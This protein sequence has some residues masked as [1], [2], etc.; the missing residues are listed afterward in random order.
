MALPLSFKK[1]LDSVNWVCQK[2]GEKHGQHKAVQ[3]TN[4][5]SGECQICEE[6]KAVTKF[7]DFGYS[8]YVK[9]N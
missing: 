7:S 8:K 6:I 3:V 9:N 1:K 5:H 4:W 2:C